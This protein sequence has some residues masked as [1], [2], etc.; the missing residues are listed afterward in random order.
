MIHENT[1]KK[2][3][4]DGAKGFVFLGEK[5]LVYRRDTNTTIFPLSIDLPGGGRE[6]CESPFETFQ[7]ETKEEFGIE[8]KEADIVFCDIVQNIIN[9]NKISY[10]FITHS[11]KF[12]EKDIVFGDEGTEWMLLTPKEFIERKDGIK[13]QQDWAREFLQQIR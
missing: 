7:R 9:P 1:F 13:G 6:G 5:I 10:A 3:E 4:F 12:T 11:L 8:I 2:V